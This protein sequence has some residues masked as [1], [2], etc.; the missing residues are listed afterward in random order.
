M[1]E[2]MIKILDIRQLYFGKSMVFGLFL[3]SVLWLLA[4]EQKPAAKILGY[5]SAAYVLLVMNPLAVNTYFSWFDKKG[6]YWELL[7]FLPLLPVIGYVFTEAV[8][9]GK[10]TIEKAAMIIAFTFVI[11]LSGSLAFSYGAFEKRETKGKLEQEAVNIIPYIERAGEEGYVIVPDTLLPN[12]RD[13]TGN[14]TLLYSRSVTADN[15][16]ICY[17]DEDLQSKAKAVRELMNTGLIEAGKLADAAKDAGVVLIVLNAGTC[18]VQ[19]M[20]ENGY[21]LIG[22]NTKYEVYKC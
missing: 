15:S 21:K 1:S 8:S 12:I 10:K 4:R 13:Y 5:G 14:I 17:G 18:D 2:F 6:V 11:I 20:E 9:K 22:Y 19:Q 16:T 7:L 3:A